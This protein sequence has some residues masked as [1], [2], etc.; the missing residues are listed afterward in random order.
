YDPLSD[1]WSTLSTTN[2]PAARFDHTAVWSGSK[3]IVWGGDAG[4]GSNPIPLDSGGLYDPLS[5]TWSTLSTTNVPAGRFDHTAVWTGSKMIVWGGFDPIS[6]TPLNSGGIYDPLS[7][8]WSSIST[9]KAPVARKSHTA[10]W[11]GSKMIVWGGLTTN[12]LTASNTGGIFDP[13]TDTWLSTSISNAPNARAFHTAVWTGSEMIVW[14]GLNTISG[15]AENTV[16]IL[17]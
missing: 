7:D 4:N 15:T 6:V 2:V 3:M 17:K 11:T 13:T 16:G 10:V 8:T 12:N 1:T 5:D 9:V 14:G